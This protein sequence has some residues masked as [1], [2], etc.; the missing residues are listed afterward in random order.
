MVGLGE[1]D[2]GGAGQ[3]AG[4]GL[5]RTPLGR[6]PSAAVLGGSGKDWAKALASTVFVACLFC[7]AKRGKWF[8]AMVMV[9]AVVSE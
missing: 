1:G 9:V 3:S 8:V 5:W 7:P 6:W 2:G 4:G